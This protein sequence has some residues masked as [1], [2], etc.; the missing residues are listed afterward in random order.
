MRALLSDPHIVGSSDGSPTMLH[1]R[2]YGSFARVIR[3]FVID[4]KVLSLEEAVRK[5]SGATAAI[6]RLDDPKVADPPRGLVREGWAA[7]LLVFDPREVRDA[8]NFEQPHRL[9]EGMRA[10]WVNGETAWREGEPNSGSGNG[11]VLRARW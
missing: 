1:P 4:E 8:A 6:Y 9:A 10:I 2:G 3:Q 5:M 11:R 7:D